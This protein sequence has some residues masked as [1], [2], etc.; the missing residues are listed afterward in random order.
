M[1]EIRLSWRN[2]WGLSLQ[3]PAFPQ[4]YNPFLGFSQ[5]KQW[6]I[7]LLI[8]PGVTVFINSY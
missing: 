5:L 1:E 4:D 7:Y 2:L 8:G 6:E 3:T